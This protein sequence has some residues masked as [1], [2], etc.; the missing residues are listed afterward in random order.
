VSFAGELG[1]GSKEAGENLLGVD[2][3]FAKFT[4]LFE[5]ASHLGHDF[6]SVVLGL[7]A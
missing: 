3:G 7:T 1:V 4:A 6:G 5:V 2:I